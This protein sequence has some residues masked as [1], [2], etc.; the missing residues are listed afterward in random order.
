VPRPRDPGVARDEMHAL[1]ARDSAAGPR[2]AGLRGMRK[3]AGHRPAPGKLPARLGGAAGTMAP[4]LLRLLLWTQLALLLTL[5]TATGIVSQCSA[6]EAVAEVLQKRID[7]ESDLRSLDVDLKGRIDPNGKRIGKRIP[8]KLSEM[9]VFDLLEDLCR[10]VKE[11]YQLTPRKPKTWASTA[12]M[13]EP[14]RNAWKSDAK[15]Q[16]QHTQIGSYCD[17]LLDEHD[18][19]LTAALQ[20]AA[21]DDDEVPV[22]QLLCRQ[23]AKQCAKADKKAK[24]E[25][26]AADAG[27]SGASDADSSGTGQHAPHPDYAGLYSD[28]HLL[29]AGHK[30]T[31]KKAK[32]AKADL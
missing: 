11:G 21:A 8:Y 19:A 30:H 10:D 23:V 32:K 5:P 16:H 22:P 3:L 17:Q 9:R 6:C 1:V 15:L 18:E 27:A 28:G 31:K 12:W 2:G 20:A 25:A 14:K 4:A 13:E 7:E 24:R 29:P 26:A